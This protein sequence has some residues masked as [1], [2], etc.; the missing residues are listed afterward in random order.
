MSHRRRTLVVGDVHGCPTELRSL[1]RLAR[2]DRV[3]LVGDLF[4][5]GPDPAGVFRVVREVGARAVM[6]NHDW[7]VL[8]PSPADRAA[9]NTVQRLDQHVPRWRQWAR[10]LPLF[11]EVGPF[12]VVHAGLHPS[13][14]LRRTTR[15][16]ALT[17][18]HWPV[19]H[20]DGPHWYD[21]YEGRRRVIFG[22]D[23][24]GGLVR[25]ERGG[26]P[27]LVGLDT[28]CV[29]GGQLSGYLVEEDRVLQVPA[30]EAYLD[31]RAR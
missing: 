2:A 20:T 18:R 7:R 3:V 28:G 19:H 30:R 16:L 1:L 27:W 25:V 11:L 5:K 6:G 26:V 4:T 24:L 9:I 8:H 12:T 17:M 22:H 29:Y 13:G 14:R 21:L 31:V 10:R 15:E 23:A